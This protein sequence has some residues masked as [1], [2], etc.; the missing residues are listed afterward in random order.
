[1]LNGQAILGNDAF[2]VHENGPKLSLN[3]LANDVFDAQY[4]GNRLI[5]S[6][7]FGSEGGRLSIAP[8]RQSLLYTPPADFSGIETFVYAVDGE[9]TAQVNVTIDAP[10]LSDDFTVTPNG[11]TRQLDVLAND[12]FW[13]GYTGPRKITAVSVG[14]AGGKVTISADRKSILYTAPKDLTSDES[15]HL[16]R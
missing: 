4:T 5:T 15:I 3:V 10:L 2:S 16:C 12:P 7:S 14:S 1:M 9:N 13:S 8:D 6:V 11:Q